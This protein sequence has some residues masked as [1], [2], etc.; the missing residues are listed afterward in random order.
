MISTRLCSFIYRQVFEI[1]G[2]SVLYNQTMVTKS[3]C[4]FE[5]IGQSVLCNQTMAQNHN[6]YVRIVSSS[7]WPSATQAEPD[8]AQPGMAQQGFDEARW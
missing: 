2:Q 6:V 1:I 3:Q 4:V 8:G 7:I 5:I